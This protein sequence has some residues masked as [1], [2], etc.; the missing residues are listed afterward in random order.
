MTL[1]L[2][3]LSN[4]PTMFLSI[5]DLVQFTA[6]QL[7]LASMPPLEGAWVQVPRIV[8]DSR[9]VERGDLFWRVEPQEC[10]TQLAYLRG[11]IG[12][13]TDGRQVEPWPG[14][15]SLH[16]EGAIDSLERL[17]DALQ[18]GQMAEIPER[19]LLDE[20][21]AESLAGTDEAEELSVDILP[22]KRAAE[23]SEDFSELKVLQLSA[24]GGIANFPLTC[25][26]SAKGQLAARCRRRAA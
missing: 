12:I 10:D 18:T 9:L 11:A 25:G 6:G 21:I 2:F 3:N 17:I 7:R 19:F 23:S 13:V 26:Q 16:V 1:A 14:T 4:S 5:H 24:R 22:L 15:F 20:P 8:L